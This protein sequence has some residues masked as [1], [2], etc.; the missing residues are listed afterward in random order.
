M[1]KISPISVILSVF[2]ILDGVG[3]LCGAMFFNSIWNA[4]RNRCTQTTSGVVV[5]L[6]EQTVYDRQSNDNTY[7]YHLLVKY[8]VNDIECSAEDSVGYGRNNCPY[9]IGDS[10]TVHYNPD[11]LSEMYLNDG[12]DM[13]KVPTVFNIIGGVLIG[14]AI[15]ILVL[16]VFRSRNY[17]T[18]DSEKHLTD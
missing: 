18:A 14:L 7:T 17:D 1:K 15:L 4:E 11:K 5:D 6:V 13:S 9:S 3:L 2:L 16:S 12:E 10:V 8:Y